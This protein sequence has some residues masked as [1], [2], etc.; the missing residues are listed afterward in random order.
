MNVADAPAALARRPP[1]RAQHHSHS[2]VAGGLLE[3]S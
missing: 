3:T 1:S 2:M